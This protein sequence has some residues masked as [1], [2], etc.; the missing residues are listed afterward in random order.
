MDVIRRNT[1]YALRMMVR[2]ARGGQDPWTSRRLAQEE[3][4]SLQLA[5][6]LLQRLVLGGLVVSRRGKTGGFRL[7][8]PP[9][10][11]DLGQVIAAIQG[12]V[13]LSGCVASAGACP[14]QSRCAVCRKLGLVQRQLEQTLAGTT[15]AELAAD[16]ERA[17][18]AGTGAPALAATLPAVGTKAARRAGA[19][20]AGH[21]A[22]GNGT[23]A[24]RNTQGGRP[25]G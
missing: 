4:V 7:A 15:L 2:L 18:A 13:L 19:A 6:K 16:A 5:A 3:G 21:R 23:T 12:P 8:G 24:Q 11:I 10:A 14:L 9:E 25:T 20:A 22:A 1:D 17:A